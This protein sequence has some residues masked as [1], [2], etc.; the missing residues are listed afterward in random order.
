MIAKVIAKMI[1]AG[2]AMA[3][4]AGYA[5]PAIAWRAPAYTLLA[6]QMNVR[7]AFDTFA[8]AQGLSIVMSDAVGGRF[9]G[10]F[11][12]VPAQEFLERVCTM[13]NL[14]WYY[15][16]AAI[17]VYAAGEIMTTLTDLAYMKA[18]DVQRLLRE[19][20]VEDARFPIKTA[21]DGEIILVSGPP[22][23]VQLVMQTIARAD[24]L[25]Q[26]RTFNEIDLRIF[27]LRHTWADQVSLRVTG[28]ES[29]MQ[30]TGV[31]QL[32]QEIMS[33]GQGE[34]ARDFMSN[35]TDSAES[36]LRD[37]M[38]ARFTPVIRADNRMNAVV[39]RDSIVRMPMY[40]RLIAELDRPQKLLEIAVTTVEMSKDDALD[41]QMSLVVSGAHK[42]IES[43]SAGGDPSS[44]MEPASIYGRGLAG[45]L[46]YVGRDTSI[47]ASLSALR[48]KGKLRHISRSSLLTLNNMAAEMTDTQ[49]YHAR[50]IGREVA[51]LEEVSAG[52]RLG[53]KPR[54]VPAAGTNGQNLVWLTM[55]LQDGG[56]ESIAVDSMPMTRSSTLETQAAVKEGETLMLAGY[57]RDIEEEAGWGIPWIRDLPLIGWIFGGESKR[58]KT[59]QRLFLLT[60]YVIELDGL[61]IARRQARRQ[62]DTL[63]EES[64]DTDSSYDLRSRK[65]RDL[66]REERENIRDEATADK[67]ERMEGEMEF[68]RE[69][70]EAARDAEKAKWRDDLERRRE[71]WKS[72]V[73]VEQGN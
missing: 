66:R 15:D 47:S 63:L 29:T 27:P 5:G 60:P 26:M 45:A 57:F 71:E 17:Y 3:A 19:L 22:R 72:R 61:D 21:S 44:L 34:Q 18:P 28:P 59:V 25:K 54:L 46:T 6:R 7:E 65:E 52:T 55:E 37:S 70:R 16:G 32:L 53:I 64:L 24:S 23:Y 68:R 4:L 11:R 73:T 33:Q 30:I 13:H 12:D 67:I 43:W 2:V 50:C 31:A 36:R 48:E 51:T 56:F 49:S 69:Q 20:G 39:V 40:E 62:R 9:S 42:E 58:S 38:Q 14:T 41:W 8:V 10:D 35:R 1:A